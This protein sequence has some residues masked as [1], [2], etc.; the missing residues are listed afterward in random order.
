MRLRA[1]PLQD[2]PCPQCRADVPSTVVCDT[3]VQ[4]RGTSYAYYDCAG[5][6]KQ[7]YRVLSFDIANTNGAND[8]IVERLKSTEEIQAVFDAIPTPQA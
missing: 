6:G 1:F 4:N 3:D 8:L 5:C 7:A 2:R